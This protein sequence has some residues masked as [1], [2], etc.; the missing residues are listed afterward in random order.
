M[1]NITLLFTIFGPLKPF[2]TFFLV[3]LILLLFSPTEMEKPTAEDRT[4]NKIHTIFVLIFG[5]LCI[6]FAIWSI[7]YYIKI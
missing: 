5:L 4:Y 6:I 2:L 7:F 3:C 1:K